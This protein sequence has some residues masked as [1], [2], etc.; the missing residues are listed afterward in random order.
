MQLGRPGQILGP[1]TAKN[2]MLPDQGFL[3][4]TLTAATW[5]G[6]DRQYNSR[7]MIDHSVI[8]VMDMFLEMVFCA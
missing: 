5:S 6:Q 7:R 1:Y 2:T 4:A 8:H 3:S